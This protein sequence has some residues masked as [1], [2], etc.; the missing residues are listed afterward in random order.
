MTRR[1]AAVDAN[2]AEIVAALRAAGVSVHS[3]HRE[4]GGCPDLL[5]GYR[6]VTQ[7][8]EVK[9]GSKPPSARK[10]TP[11]QKEW[12]AAWRGSPVCVVDNVA[13]AL[14]VFGVEMKTPASR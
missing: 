8:L 2:Q 11:D 4:G 1:A 10:L 3:L 14:A 5:C 6:G 12:F 13:E 7:L 9:D